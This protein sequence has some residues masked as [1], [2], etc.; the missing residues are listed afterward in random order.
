[1]HL[2]LVQSNLHLRL[3]AAAHGAETGRRPGYRR[4]HCFL[5]NVRNAFTS[6]RPR[7]RAWDGTLCEE[8]MLCRCYQCARRR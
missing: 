2:L 4:A 6:A 3:D 7:I 1:M 8:G 5:E